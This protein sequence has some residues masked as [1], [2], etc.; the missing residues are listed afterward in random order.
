MR[1]LHSI[2][3]WAVGA[4]TPCEFWRVMEVT[5]KDRIWPAKGECQDAV[6]GST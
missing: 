2:D 6:A 3:S 4:A 1:H 5:E